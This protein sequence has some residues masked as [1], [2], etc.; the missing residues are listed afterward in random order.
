M[1]NCRGLKRFIR[2]HASSHRTTPVQNCR[3]LKQLFEVYKHTVRTTPVQNC[4]GLK[5]L[6]MAL[7]VLI[8]TTPVQNCR[9]LKRALNEKHP[10]PRT[11]PVQNCRGVVFIQKSRTLCTFASGTACYSYIKLYQNEKTP[12]ENS[13]GVAIYIRTL[14]YLLLRQ[15]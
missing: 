2:S 12:G 14:C 15:G 13:P 7:S 9:G 6:S 3:G 5:P 10:V 11:T 1:Q 8:G 4:R